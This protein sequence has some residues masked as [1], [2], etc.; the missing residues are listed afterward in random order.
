MWRPIF[1][2]FFLRLFNL[3]PHYQ[4]VCVVLSF[5]KYVVGSILCRLIFL[6]LDMYHNTYL[7]I[8]LS[9]H[10]PFA[11]RINLMVDLYLFYHL[12]IA[13]LFGGASI[14]SCS[15]PISLANCQ[16]SDFIRSAIGDISTPP[17]PY[18]V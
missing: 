9:L 6:F 17:S 13:R 5:F 18:L 1:F 15:T 16:T 2:F 11:H 14:I 7:L 12:P 8:H 10:V 4:D 3:C